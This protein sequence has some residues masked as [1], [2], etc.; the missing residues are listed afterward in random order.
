MPSALARREARAQ[1]PRE[2]HIGPRRASRGRCRL[3]WPTLDPGP[4]RTWYF[5]WRDKVCVPNR[6][7]AK[8]PPPQ[9]A[10]H[11]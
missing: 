4:G 10:G 5:E 11:E 9:A 3:H 6:A 1:N 7:L 2:E 8:K